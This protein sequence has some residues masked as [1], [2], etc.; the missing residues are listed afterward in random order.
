[1]FGHYLEGHVVTGRYMGQYVVSGTVRES[2]VKLGGQLIH[3]VDLDLP[4]L[5]SGRQRDSVILN[6]QDLI[7]IQEPLAQA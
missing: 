7:S 6:D 1:M 4:V 5:V 3:Y 2:R